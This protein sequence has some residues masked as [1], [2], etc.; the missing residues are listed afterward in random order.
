M[1]I[2]GQSLILHEKGSLISKFDPQTTKL[3][4]VVRRAEPLSTGGGGSTSLSS[5]NGVLS[6]S[7]SVSP[8]WLPTFIGELIT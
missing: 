4:L 1:Q 7:D 2:Y 6:S 3:Y 8:I 5:C